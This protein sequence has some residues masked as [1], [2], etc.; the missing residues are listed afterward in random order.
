MLQGVRT[1]LATISAHESLSTTPS[2]LR[3]SVI[4]LRQSGSG[5][6]DQREHLALGQEMKLGCRQQAK[7]LPQFGLTKDSDTPDWKLGNRFENGRGGM[8]TSLPV[9]SW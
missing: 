2:H 7:L 8:H 5:K 4:P 3:Y 1:M 9:H 6:W